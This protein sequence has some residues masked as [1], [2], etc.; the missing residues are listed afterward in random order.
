MA[1]TPFGGARLAAFLFFKSVFGNEYSCVVVVAGLG[2]VPAGSLI[3]AASLSNL[4][5]LWLVLWDFFDFP[6]VRWNTS[7]I[8]PVFRFLRR[9][10]LE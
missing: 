6:G 8:P 5:L 1:W 10:R 9:L 7:T 4:R 2:L 3:G